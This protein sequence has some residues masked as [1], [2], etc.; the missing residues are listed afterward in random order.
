[1]ERRPELLL[2]VVGEGAAGACAA[3]LAH[4]TQFLQD[5]AEEAVVLLWCV[6]G[7]CGGGGWCCCGARGERAA[8]VGRERCCCQPGYCNLSTRCL[9]DPSA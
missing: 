7:C 5:A 6:R 4:V 1:M 8:A 9:T 3:G 2:R